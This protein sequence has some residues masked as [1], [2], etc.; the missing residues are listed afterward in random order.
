[1]NLDGNEEKVIRN[2]KLNY[3]YTSPNIDRTG[4]TELTG[5]NKR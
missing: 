1:M 4:K 5:E 3:V 2:I